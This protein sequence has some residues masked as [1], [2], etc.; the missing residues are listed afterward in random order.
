MKHYND[1]VIHAVLSL[2]YSML[3]DLKVFDAN[4]IYYRNAEKLISL[5]NNDMLR[6]IISLYLRNQ[7]LTD[8]QVPKGIV[9]RRYGMKEDCRNY[10][11]TIIDLMMQDTKR[12]GFRSEDIINNIKGKCKDIIFRREYKYSWSITADRKK[13]GLDEMLMEDIER[14]NLNYEIDTLCKL[15]IFDSSE[16]RILLSREV[17]DLVHMKSPKNKGGIEEAVINNDLEL[18]LDQAIDNPKKFYLFLVSETLNLDRYMTLKLDR[19]RYIS[20]HKY[21]LI[22]KESSIMIMQNI[23]LKGILKKLCRTVSP[24]LYHLISDWNLAIESMILANGVLLTSKSS[25]LLDRLMVSKGVEHL[26]II[27][28]GDLNAFVPAV[29]LNRLKDLMQKNDI[30]FIENFDFSFNEDENIISFDLNEIKSL[31]KLFQ[32]LDDNDFENAKVYYYN[33]K[34]IC[35]I[36][37]ELNAKDN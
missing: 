27:K 20:A 16:D 30:N 9:I 35:K 22:G 23:S 2:T 7:I 18:I 36:L 33:L 15:G 12:K 1:C 13:V 6:S 34:R 26:G 8:I 11:E 29:H 19:H 32:C 3:K 17:Y 28:L 21:N 14:Y 37:G 5:D 24:T 25:L 4:F 31:G 10:R